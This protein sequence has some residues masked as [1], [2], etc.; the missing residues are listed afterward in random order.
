MPHARHT[1]DDVST[2]PSRRKFFTQV[3]AVSVALGAAPLRLHAG[4]P[5][6]DSDSSAPRQSIYDLKTDAS[7]NQESRIRTL[8]LHYTATP[9][10]RAKEILTAPNRTPA[11]SSH[12]LVP[13]AAGDN[14]RFVVYALVPESR[15]A[16]H[17]GRSEWLGERRLNGTSIGIEIV[18]LGFPATDNRLPLE[19]RQWYEYPAAQIAV[20]A[21]LVADIV[22][23]HQIAPNRIVGHADI[24]PGRKTDP[25]PKFPWKTLA[26]EYNL[27]AW[28]DADTVKWYENRAPY[29]CDVG[30]LQAKLLAYGYDTPQTGQID[31]ATKNVIE[32]FQMHFCAEHRYDGVPDVPTVAILDALLEKYLGWPRPPALGTGAA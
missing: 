5:A 20:V 17:A 24:A 21:E 3:T 31:Q 8:V 7:P 12:Y 4:A 30:A 22:A 10:E 29:A 28:P 25:G 18:N 23:R 27:G 32:S 11:V 9:F 2:T 14:D 16:H 13:D 19:N 6:T 15:L 26:T 1:P